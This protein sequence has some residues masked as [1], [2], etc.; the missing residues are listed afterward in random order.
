MHT[1]WSHPENYPLF[2]RESGRHLLPWLPG[3]IQR[4]AAAAAAN[5]LR[6][7]LPLIGVV[8]AQIAIL[9]SWTAAMLDMLDRHFA[10][11]P[12]LLGRSPSIG[13]FG[14]VGSMY[15]HLGRDPWPK[16]EL[17]APRPHLR[18]WIDRMADP[19]PGDAAGFADA[20]ILPPTLDPVLKS[21]FAE[22]LPMVEG[23][24]AEV[25][26]AASSEGEILPRGLG[27]IEFPMGVG[28]YRRAATPFTLWMV[29]R[30]LD[31]FHAM[32]GE[33]QEAVRAWLAGFGA[34]RLLVL[35]IPRLRRQALRVALDGTEQGNESRS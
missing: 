31:V 27:I 25:R 18:A 34:E 23:I 11:T 1:R 29:Q 8:P 12:F 13:D 26:A 22:F 10:E 35:E 14:L 33:D 6:R 2:E 7:F 9:D 15:G 19:P 17:V 20:D 24:L 4:R 32:T 5:R 21:I 3:F 16:R 28:H 30:V